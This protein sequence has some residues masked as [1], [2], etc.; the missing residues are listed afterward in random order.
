MLQ[1]TL[2]LGKSRISIWKG[3]YEICE[4][5]RDKKGNSNILKAEVSIVLWSDASLPLALVNAQ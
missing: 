2:Q 4:G 1:N 5:L 3:F